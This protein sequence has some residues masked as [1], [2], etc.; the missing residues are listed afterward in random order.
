ML[1]VTR[2]QKVVSQLS[3]RLSVKPLATTAHYH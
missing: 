3:C 2:L 1:G